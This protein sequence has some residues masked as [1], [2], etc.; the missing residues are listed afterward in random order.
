MYIEISLWD[1]CT[2]FCH[3]VAESIRTLSTQTLYVCSEFTPAH[4]LDLKRL[5]R[6][7]KMQL[8]ACGSN[9]AA[10]LQSPPSCQR[11]HIRRSN[12]CIHN[13]W[14]RD[15]SALPYCPNM[16]LNAV[17]IAAANH[18]RVLA[19]LPNATILDL[20][21]ELKLLGQQCPELLS[22]ESLA[23][24]AHEIEIVFALQGMVELGMLLEGGDI[25]LLTLGKYGDK[26]LERHSP[27]A[28]RAIHHLAFGLF[29][30]AC[31]L[32]HATIQIRS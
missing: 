19:S 12:P 3:K 31:S 21:G 13:D 10:N 6:S 23:R 18:I 11:Y 5:H 26:T 22:E 9:E 28:G 32:S 27:S 4:S 1:S 7:S 17:K 8:Y 16:V 14:G 20:D 15:G 30:R 2:W 25:L 29:P 24:Q